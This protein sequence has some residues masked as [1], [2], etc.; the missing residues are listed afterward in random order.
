MWVEGSRWFGF[1]F[2]PMSRLVDT[3]AA[4]VVGS[5]LVAVVGTPPDL[6]RI[7]RFGSLA[8]CLDDA[9]GWSVVGC[10]KS[11]IHRAPLQNERE[12]AK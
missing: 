4:A 9:C 5:P 3:Q 11:R 8:A 10:F 1:C 2:T 7:E 12:G 6:A